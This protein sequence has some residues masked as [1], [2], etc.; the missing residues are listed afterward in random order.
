VPLKNQLRILFE[1][2]IKQAEALDR[3][4]VGD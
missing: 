1:I 4:W 2:D 3:D